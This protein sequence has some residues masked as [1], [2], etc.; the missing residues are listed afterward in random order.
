LNAIQGIVLRGKGEGKK[1]KGKNIPTFPLLHQHL[2]MDAVDGEG[3]E[4]GDLTRRE[5]GTH[6]IAERDEVRRGGREGGAVFSPSSASSASS[7]LQ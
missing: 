3:R 6:T 4:A 2:S 1:E 5:A 7:P